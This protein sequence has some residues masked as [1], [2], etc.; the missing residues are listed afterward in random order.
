[1][2]DIFLLCFIIAKI[3]KSK[4]DIKGIQEKQGFRVYS[5]RCEDLLFL[6]FY[7]QMLN[8]T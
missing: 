1:M 3:L 7:L 2:T 8:D 6:Q 4:L 5:F